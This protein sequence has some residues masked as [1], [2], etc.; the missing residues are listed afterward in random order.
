MITGTTASN[1]VVLDVSK[2]PY[3]IEPGGRRLLSSGQSCTVRVA[4]YAEVVVAVIQAIN[5]R[6]VG[7]ICVGS[8]LTQAQP[9][10][11]ALEM[12]VSM[13][14]VVVETE[15]TQVRT[16]VQKKTPLGAGNCLELVD[17]HSNPGTP[18]A[19]I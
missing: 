3:I 12:A 8:V 1:I 9:A 11:P 5:G 6:I 16:F 19:L 18:H 17:V 13:L 10:V 15:V 7:T 2:N 14:V 4:V